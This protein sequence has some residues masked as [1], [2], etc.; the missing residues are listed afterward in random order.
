M[1]TQDEFY[2]FL[3]PFVKQYLENTDDTVG[4]YME[5]A[6]NAED[7]AHFEQCLAYCKDNLTKSSL[8]LSNYLN[9]QVGELFDSYYRLNSPFYS[10]QDKKRRVLEFVPAITVRISMDEVYEN[11]DI[12]TEEENII[13]ELNNI[14]DDCLSGFS[15]NVIN[16]I[17]R[18][19]GSIIAALEKD[20]IGPWMKEELIE[21]IK[22]TLPESDL[23]STEQNR[24]TRVLEKVEKLRKADLILGTFE[25][26]DGFTRGGT[27]PYGTITLY[28]KSISKIY[29]YSKIKGAKSVFMHELFHAFHYCC[30]A[31]KGLWN[32]GGSIC[33][34]V[35]ESLAS[36]YQYIYTIDTLQDERIANSISYDWMDK[37]LDDWPYK[38]ASYI[39]SYAELDDKIFSKIFMSSLGDWEKSYT[40]ILACR[41]LLESSEYKLLSGL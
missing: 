8:L 41:D 15:D 21:P 29:P 20:N 25:K 39:L 17:D 35:K 23:S 16:E 19:I 2:S 26:N 31:N 40:A 5:I 18:R 9:D 24:I 38:G 4:F 11:P 32:D 30:L 7:E 14:K 22:K 1:Y 36:Y 27:I 34:I 10:S 12:R 33:K 6:M 3:N 13:W 28:P 37:T